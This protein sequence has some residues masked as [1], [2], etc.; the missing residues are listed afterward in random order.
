M[1]KP[2]IKDIFLLQRPSLQATLEDMQ[3]V[4][5]LIDTLEANKDRCVGM[6]ASMIGVPKDIIIFKV[7][8]E[9]MVL[10]NPV[11]ID[12]KNAYTCEEGCLS[13]DG[14]HQ[15]TRYEKITV[16]YQDTS[17]K[18][19]TKVFRGYVAQIIQHEV[20]HLHGILI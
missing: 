17:F 13:I 12:K 1:I 14:I 16:K 9:S 20:D 18:L 2:I 8:K 19:K 4:Q 6:S 10:L 7:Q 3:T 11:I 15:T 5:D